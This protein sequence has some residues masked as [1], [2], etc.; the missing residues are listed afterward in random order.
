MGT[1]ISMLKTP[2]LFLFLGL[3]LSILGANALAQNIQVQV[4]NGGST[5]DFGELRS[6]DAKGNPAGDLSRK[7]VRLTITNSNGNP[8][9]VTQALQA[10][11][12]NER[13]AELDRGAMTFRIELESGGGIVRTGDG[14]SFESGEE[15]IYVSDDA[16]SDAVLV[17]TYDFKVPGA[18]KAGRYHSTV[19]YRVNGR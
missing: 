14:Q 8:Y 5:I 17:V 1:F 9:I 13:G 10:D 16:G 18:Q 3:C 7:Q 2:K 4:I 6:L 12:R 15:E 11:P 19:S